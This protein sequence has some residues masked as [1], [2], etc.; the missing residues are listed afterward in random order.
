MAPAPRLGTSVAELWLGTLER[1]VGRAAHEVK[2]AMNGLG[3]NLEVVRMRSARADAP[4][5]GVASFA[6]TAAG[7]FELLTAMTEALLA[8]ARPARA[9]I[10]LGAILAQ[11][12]ALLVPA[13]RADGVALEVPTRLPEAV[14]LDVDG[15]VAR[16]LLGEALLAAIDGRRD[17]A[18]T[19][20]LES[21]AE[22]RIATGAPP[23]LELRADLVDPARWGGV[24][25]EVRS[26]GHWLTIAFPRIHATAHHTA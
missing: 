19:V 17:A 14:P 22:V 6:E 15:D 18:C 2:G 8:L 23:A 1:V 10:D 21:K 24:G 9:P 11:Y 12:S 25:V 20:R 4:A 5:S 26:E 3:V 16:L 7:Q 13:A